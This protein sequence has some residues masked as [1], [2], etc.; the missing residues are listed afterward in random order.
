MRMQLPY[1]AYLDDYDVLNVYMSKN[2]YEGK[3]RIFH[4]KDSKERILPLTI[5]SI[6]DRSNGY[7][8]Y[9]LEIYS[10]IDMGEEYVLYD[11]HCQTTVCQY[12]HIV[13]TD[14]FN[15]EFAYDGSDLGLTFTQKGMTFKLWSPVAFKILLVLRFEDQEKIFDMKREVGG[16]FVCHV[17]EKLHGWKYTFMVR[18]NGQ[19]QEIV[20]PYS[21]FIGENSLYSVVVDPTSLPWPKYISLPPLQSPCDAIIYEASIRD[22]TS[23]TNIGVSYPKKFAGFTEENEITKAKNTGF[24]YIRSLGVTHIQLMPVFDFGSVD[25]MYPNIFYNWGYDPMHHRCIEGVYSTDCTDAAK[26]VIEF[27]NLVHDCHKAGLRVV[28]DIV[29]NHVYKKEKYALEQLVPN[30]YFLMNREGDFSNG[31]FCGNDIDTQPIMSHRYFVDTI[32]RIVEWF[33]VDGFRFDLMGILDINIMN[34]IEEVCHKIKPDIMLY[35]EGWDMPSYVPSSL[36]ASFNNQSKMPRIGHFNDFF[37]EVIRGSNTELEQ[38]GYASGNEELIDD[39]LECM[40]ASVHRRFDTPEKSI[41]YVECHDNHTLWDKNRMC[42]ANETSETRKK[43]QIL[44]NAMTIFAQG[45][46]FIHAGQEF[47]R[48]KQNLHNS[49]NRSDYYNRINYI[50]RDRNID[51]V[52]ATKMLLRVRK[53]YAC[54]RYR[55]KKDIEDNVSFEVLSNGA[56]K[57]D[58]K[59]LDGQCI[60]FFNPSQDSLWYKIDQEGI[61]LFDSAACNARKTREI[62]I[63][64]IGVVVV[65]IE[66]KQSLTLGN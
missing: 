29:F 2:F 39:V 24:S 26:R 9:E 59:D 17:P 44:T 66:K 8:H 14:R 21:S 32:K 31:S 15:S 13:K 22:M 27:A 47:G 56:F 41:N 19:W 36:R 50:R 55:T 38:R 52:N 48:T 49:Y 61:V 23:Q 33:D 10:D 58:C 16:L 11:E 51:I 30:Y 43:R 25:E 53:D 60:V 35:G 12:S 3:S 62:T 1:E 6:S 63:P 37:R 40:Q 20:D 54:F 4:I 42:C 7:T 18:V 65:R 34:E 28:C 46:P 5:R 45:V 57:Y 64:P